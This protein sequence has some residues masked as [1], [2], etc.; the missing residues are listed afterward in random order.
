MNNRHLSLTCWGGVGVVTG[1][2]FLLDDGNTK[3]LIDC[4]LLQGVAEAH[5]ENKKSFPYDPKSI[6]FLFITHAHLDHIGKVA[7]LVKDGF[8]GTIYSTPETKSITELMLADAVNIMSFEAKRTGEEPLYGA[9]DVARAFSLW[10]TISYHEKKT[11]ADGFEVYLK[12]AGHILG[13][14]IYEFTYTDPQNGSKKKVVFTGDLGNSPSTILRDAESVIDADY[15]IMDSVYGDRNHESKEER[16]KRFEQIIKETVAS[17]GALVIP[18]FSLERTQDILY[19]INNLVEE[20]KIK[21]VPVFLDSPLAIKVTEIY[22]RISKYYSPAVR[23]EIASGDNIFNFPK[24]KE[25]ARSQDSKAILSVPNPKIII[26]GSGMSNA[27]RVVHHET[28]YLPDPK[29]TILLM[30]YQAVGTLGRQIQEGAKKVSIHGKMVTVRARVEMISGFSA[31]KDSDH[32][33]EF[34]GGTA[35]T[36]KQVFVAMGEPKASLFLVQRLRDQVGIN[37][38]YPEK[39]KVY[40]LK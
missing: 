38:I 29:S 19:E 21:S 33:V 10:Q 4:G 1:A 36:V 15:M 20:H 23:E 32:L 17:G 8:S 9:D 2:N 40:E 6:N 18:A 25:T 7:K 3:I 13:S 30:G 22:K 11:F 35:E 26:A 34:V 14:S 16:E 5:E 28:N 31:H 37:A 27:G 24:I 12:D 39:G